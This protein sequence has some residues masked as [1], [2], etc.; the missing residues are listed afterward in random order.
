M[1]EVKRQYIRHPATIPLQFELGSVTHSCAT[2]D[3]T[4]GGL[5][6]IC[7]QPIHVDQT[8]SITI[9]H[10]DPDFEAKGVVRWCARHGHKYLVGVAF[11]DQAVKYAVRM[12]EQVLHIEHYRQERLNQGV[13]LTSQEAAVEWISKY[14]ADFPRYD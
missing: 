12:V 10:C 5:C 6:F 7:A 4:E 2:K 13:E 8:I 14:A 3:V 11:E 9:D 1:A